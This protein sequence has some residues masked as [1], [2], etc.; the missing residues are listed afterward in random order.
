MLEL[1]K[2]LGSGE[3][4]PLPLRPVFSVVRINELLFHAEVA[5][6]MELKGMNDTMGHDGLVLSLLVFGSLPTIPITK[7]E[8]PTQ[9]KH[10]AALRTVLE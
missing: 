7:T 2:S 6:R 1:I 4:Y 9:L 10:M 3:H 8:V 5:L